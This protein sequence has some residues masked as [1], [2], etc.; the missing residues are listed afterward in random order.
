MRYLLY[1]SFVWIQGKAMGGHSAIKKTGHILFMLLIATTSGVAQQRSRVPEAKAGEDTL[2]FQDI[3]DLQEAFIDAS[4]MERKDGIIVGELGR[5]GGD[6]AMILEL[7]QEIADH[8]HGN[9]DGLLIVHKSK[10]VFES[11]YKKGRMDLPH[12]QASA[13]KVYT[14]LALGRA[15]QMGYL[16][17]DDL[18]QPL[19]HFLKD[20]DRT[21]LVSG[22]EKI[23]LHQALTMCSGIRISPEK[24]AELEKDPDVLK[25]QGLVQ[26]YLEASAPITNASQHFKYQ[27]FD[28]ML[29]MQ[30]ID[31]VVPGT[32]KDFIQKELLGKMGIT[33]Y[34]WPDDISG[35]PKAGGRSKMTARNMV[36]WGMLVMN[37]GK[38]KD[39][40]LFPQAY[41]D[42]AIHRIVRHSDDEN[43]T[44]VGEVTNVGYGYFWWQSDLKGGDK[45]Y[46]ST[47]AQ[48]GSGQC[49]IL[50]DELD[51]MVV[52]TV[53]RLEG[54]VLQ[55]TAERILPAFIN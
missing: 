30:V 16:S 31:A 10:L 8:Q 17:M 18:D 4:P 6:K 3:P 35:L 43:F 46:F 22:A 2:S 38:W 13:T 53:H 23:T 9:Y 54:S 20:L 33:N 28:P 55:L 26:A 19:I 42:R 15:I 12:P 7:A 39:E 36:K 27:Y 21:K 25:R 11:Y 47:S 52:S 44:D 34:G 24:R 29:V 41:I 49:I 48:G 40:Q 5:D 14:S 37:H 32:A 45:N 50:I 1:L 51:L